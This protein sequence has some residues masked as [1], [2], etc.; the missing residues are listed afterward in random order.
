MHQFGG[1]FEEIEEREINRMAMPHKDLNDPTRSIPYSVS[2]PRWMRKYIRETPE[3]NPSKMLQE[4]V[5]EKKKELERRKRAEDN[6]VI[7]VHEMEEKMRDLDQS[8]LADKI[9][10]LREQLK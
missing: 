9:R 3:I 7:L 10:D 1:N 6:L 5:L 8:E 2:I 4:A